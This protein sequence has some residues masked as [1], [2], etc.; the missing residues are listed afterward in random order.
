[1]KIMIALFIINVGLMCPLT[2]G[3]VE[4]SVIGHV[5]EVLIT[6]PRYE[7]EDVAWS[8]LMETVVVTEP[9][10]E[11][12]DVAWS[13]LMETVIV[14]SSSYDGPGAFSSTTGSSSA[15]TNFHSDIG[16]HEIA[17]NIGLFF[18]IITIMLAGLVIALYVVLHS[19][20]RKRRL[21]PCTCECERTL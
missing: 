13:G 14:S 4:D 20:H 3:L 21:A 19:G 16:S 2:A 8:G 12:E 17:A 7:H 1:M 9:R 18:Y 6:A 5:P 10:Y 11:F 15:R